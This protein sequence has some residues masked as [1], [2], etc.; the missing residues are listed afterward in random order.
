MKATCPLF[1]VHSSFESLDV[2]VEI[3]ILIEARKLGRGCGGFK[4]RRV[5]HRW[6]EGERRN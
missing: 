1:Y 4:R 5:K 3:G 6:C 2:G